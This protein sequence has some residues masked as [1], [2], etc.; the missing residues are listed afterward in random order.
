MGGGLF[1]LLAREPSSSTP[2]SSKTADLPP[3]A[4]SYAQR[5]GAEAT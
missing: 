2:R 4:Q 5:A 3:S 1:S